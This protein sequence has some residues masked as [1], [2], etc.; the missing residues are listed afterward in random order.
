MN[1]K[2]V[3]YSVKTSQAKLNRIVEIAHMH[4]ERKEPLL[5]LVP[6]QNAWDF[7]DR[8]LWSTPA[9]SFIPHPS[10]LIQ[11]RLS[12]D[13]AF[14]SFFNL[15]PSPMIQEGVK[16]I[17]ELEDH[18]TPEK[19]RLSEQRYLAYREKGFQIIVEV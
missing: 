9:E 8:F 14:S 5:F 2:I 15:S 11:L 4:F 1:P 18:T 17:Y 13:N 3:F 10:K 19:Y 12:I 6:D 7:L 16:T